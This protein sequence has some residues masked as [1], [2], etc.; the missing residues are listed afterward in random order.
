MVGEEY[1]CLWRVE[2]EYDSMEDRGEN[3]FFCCRIKN[4]ESDRK[5]VVIKVWKKKMK[6]EFF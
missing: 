2:R 5:D 6:T 4:G 3:I 1:E